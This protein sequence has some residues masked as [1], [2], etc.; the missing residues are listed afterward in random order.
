MYGNLKL[1]IATTRNKYVSTHFGP[2]A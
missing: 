2:L 1:K